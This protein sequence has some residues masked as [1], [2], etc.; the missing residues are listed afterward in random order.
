MLVCETGKRCS[1]T[2][3][4]LSRSLYVY[5]YPAKSATDEI[6]STAWFCTQRDWLQSPKHQP[7]QTILN[8]HRRHWIKLFVVTLGY[9]ACFNGL[10]ISREIQANA[11]H[12]MP[13]VSGRWKS[14]AFEDMTQMPTAI[15]T[16]DLNPRHAEAPIFVTSYSTRD[17]VEISWPTAPRFELLLRLVQR[18]VTT[19]ASV[20][21]LA[22]VVLV[23]FARSWWLS[24]LLSEDSE[25]F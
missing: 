11:V 2:C 9:A 24:T 4:N 20:H 21:S 3:L 18:C 22:G 13:L 17:T 15:R 5:A 19:S 1:K 23:K 6:Y 14:F 7:S 16:H 8:T 10:I 25:L 12:T